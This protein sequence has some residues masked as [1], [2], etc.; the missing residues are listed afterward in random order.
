MGVFDTCERRGQSMRDLAVTTISSRPQHKQ[1]P[2]PALF[3]APRQ[4]PQAR[5]TKPKG[6]HAEPWGKSTLLT[7]SSSWVLYVRPVVGSWTLLHAPSMPR[8]EAVHERTRDGRTGE[9]R[10][11][12]RRQKRMSP[13]VILGLE[14]GQAAFELVHAHLEEHGRAVAVSDPSGTASAPCEAWVWRG[15]GAG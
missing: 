10:G 3:S 15:G 1:R 5:G 8:A 13:T 2:T 12:R 11:S 4:G 6:Q 7:T 9:G 14:L